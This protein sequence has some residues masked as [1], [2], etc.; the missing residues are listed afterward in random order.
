MLVPTSLTW[1]FVT[2]VLWEAGG[3][4]HVPFRARTKWAD[5]VAYGASSRVAAAETLVRAARVILESA[6]M[7]P[8]ICYISH[9]GVFSYSL[10]RL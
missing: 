5:K 1:K 8:A 6:V 3:S 10:V 7:I 4:F 2:D 9:T